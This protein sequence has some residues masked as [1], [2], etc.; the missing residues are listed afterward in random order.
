VPGRHFFRKGDPRRFHL[1]WCPVGGAVA[2][3]QLRLRDKL[4]ARPDLAARYAQ[5]KRA[6]SG[7]FGIDRAEYVRLKEPIILEILAEDEGPRH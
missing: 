7:R 1:H 3:S 6:L 4:R 5:A 2:R